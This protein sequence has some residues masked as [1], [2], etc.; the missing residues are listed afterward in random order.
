MKIELDLDI[1][2]NNGILTIKSKS[3]KTLVFY[4]DHIVQ[5]KIQMVTLAELSEITIEEICN[6]FGYKT[7]KSFYDVRRCVLQNDIDSLLPKKT[8]P[9]SPPKRTP[10]LEKHIIQIR[11]NSDKNMYEIT[12][13]L[14]QKGFNIKSRLVG[15]ILNDYGI[16]KKKPLRPK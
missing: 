6:I 3:G 5:K 8:G 13:E 10:E 11:L 14:N 16:S 4:N 9:K 7:R 12:D 15:N 2:Y 1:K